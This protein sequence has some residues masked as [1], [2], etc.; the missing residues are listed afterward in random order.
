MFSIF[1]IS[2]LGSGKFLGSSSFFLYWYWL[3]CYKQ[4]Q[5][6][7]P[8]V[9]SDSCHNNADGENCCC[10]TTST[11]CCSADLGGV[12]NPGVVGLENEGYPA[13]LGDMSDLE[14]LDDGT[15]CF[16]GGFDITDSLA[17]TSPLEDN[18]DDILSR[19]VRTEE[20]DQEEEKPCPVSNNPYL[21]GNSMT[22]SKFNHSFCF[23][24]DFP[25]L[26]VTFFS[27]FNHCIFVSLPKTRHP[28][29]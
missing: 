13:I 3:S 1:P 4:E 21:P 27:Y 10:P 2:L 8:L 24:R 18:D 6:R 19:I 25:P 12:D 5:R 20:E 11:S 15:S 23:P 22:H 17:A 28:Y 9:K 26:A 29:L 7:E 14:P 16:A